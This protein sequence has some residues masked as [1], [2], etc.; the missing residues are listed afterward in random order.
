MTCLALHWRHPVLDF[1]CPNRGIGTRSRKRQRIERE[2]MRSFCRFSDRIDYVGAVAAGWVR[3]VR[4]RIRDVRNRWET[5]NN[6]LSKGSC[7]DWLSLALDCLCCCRQ[8]FW[9]PPTRKGA[10]SG[11]GRIGYSGPTP[12]L[13]PVNGTGSHRKIL[14]WRCRASYEMWCHCEAR[15]RA[16]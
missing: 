16:V 7:W 4:M 14:K 2:P 1:L 6:C 15:I 11:A 12:S 10:T 9:N 3:D 8:R 5:Q 13:T